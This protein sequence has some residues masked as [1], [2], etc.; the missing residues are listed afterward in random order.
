[1]AFFGRTPIFSDVAKIDRTNVIAVL[2]DALSTHN[3][4]AAEIDALYKI[5]RGDQAILQ[6]TKNI[7]PDIVDNVVVNK[8]YEIVSFKTSYLLNKPITYVNRSTTEDYVDEINILNDYMFLENKTTHDKEIADDFSITGVAYR[9]V[10]PN[11]NAS[12]GDSPFK[13]YTLSPVCTFLIRKSSMEQE[14]LAGVT[15]VQKINGEITYNV[16]TPDRYFVIESGVIVSEQ[17]TILGE[18]P[19]IEY[20][21][22]TFRLGAFEVV[23]GLL[24]KINVVE[25]NRI[26]ATEQAVQSITWF[27]NVDIPEGSVEKLKE[28][29]SAFIF[30]TTAD[31]AAGADIKQIETNLNQS[32]QQVLI[33]DLIKRVLEITGMPSIGDGMTSD[34][35][36]NGSTIVRNGWYNAEA[37][38][39]DS[40][41]LWRSSEREFLKIVLKICKMSK[42]SDIDIPLYAIEEKF[43]RRNYEDIMTK[44]T[45]LTTLLGCEKIHPM[46]AYQVA[47]LSPDSD[48]AYKLGMEWY[49]NEAKKQQK[50]LDQMEEAKNGGAAGTAAEEYQTEQPGDTNDRVGA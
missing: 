27:N 21:N 11:K 42:Y 4:N 41:K 48:S 29:P 47:G 8:A 22:N 18:V 24:D 28:S 1:M 32:D 34:S 10:F 12:D 40:E 46:T 23:V 19:I 31:G 26:E 35:S 43:T 16:Y 37:R 6:R 14:V 39:N 7:R 5:Y 15:Y 30:T 33:N 13:I 45:V 2:N 44:S 49:E 20:V 25:S 38:A 3:K 17:P 50:Q 9:A 36:N